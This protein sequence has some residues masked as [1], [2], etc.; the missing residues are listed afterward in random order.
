MRTELLVVGG[1]PAGYTAAIRGAERGLETVLVERDSV[2]GVCLNRGCIPSKAL[3]HAADVAAAAR[4]GNIGVE[5]T[6]DI[7]LGR[8]R[9]WT[10]GVVERLRAGVRR[11]CEDAGVRVRRGIAAFESPGRVTV[12]GPDAG[13]ISFEHAVVATG[14]EPA[15]LPGFDFDAGPVHDAAGLLARESVP[16]RL[17]VVGAGYIGT[18]LATGFAKLGA[19]V[20]V[21]EAED[22]ILPRFSAALV[23][24]VERWLRRAGVAVRTGERATGWTET[25]GGIAVR[26]D[27][28]ELP[29]DA[30]LVAVGREP[31][32]DALHPEA[33]G[34]ELD[35]DGFLETNGFRTTTESVLAVG[36]VRGPPLLAHAAAEEGRLA[37]GMA[38]GDAE[39]TPGAIPEVVFSEPEL[40]V[41]G[42]TA[43]EL[44]NSETDPTVGRAS[45]RANGR[46]HTRNDA[47]GFVRVVADSGTVV[48]AE[49]VGP[50]ASE[51]VGELALAVENE[52]P[53]SALA[54]TV[55]PHPTLS[56]AVRDAARDATG[57]R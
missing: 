8:W 50:D 44:R 33:A 34:L 48:G 18:E 52:L 31:V 35:S 22:R 5:A 17:A 46:A 7:D 15:A 27:S 41:V 2:G 57:E 20:T 6:P 21:V 28:G 9:E 16:D 14:S 29:A 43:R 51:L 26:T 45:F 37:A 54:R 12:S 25:E 32:T 3:L 1:G 38:A 42:R 55:R 36:D 53:V 47:A 4:N 23:R 13:D 11:R 30:V 24:P 10:D 19:D 40:A 49:L 56:E 39:R